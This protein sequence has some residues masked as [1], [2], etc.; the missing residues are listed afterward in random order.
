MIA[1]Y[2]SKRIS[3][4]RLREMA[5]VNRDG[6]TRSGLI[7]GAENI[8]L[9]TR[10]VK[11]TLE[12]LGK[13]PLPAVSRSERVATAHWEGKHFVVIWKI[14]AKQVIIGDLAIGQLTLSRAEFASNP[15]SAP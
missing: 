12:G 6:A 4:N 10:P 9:S 5:N 3:V 14:T 11:A 1:R 15:H 8:G 2:W 13:Q 7:T